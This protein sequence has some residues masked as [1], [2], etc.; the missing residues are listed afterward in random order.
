[1]AGLLR[2]FRNL[3]NPPKYMVPMG[4]I[5]IDVSHPLANGLIGCW[6]PGSSQGRNLA[7]MSADLVPSS[8]LDMTSDGPGLLSAGTSQDYKAVM[9]AVFTNWTVGFSLF[10]RGVRLGNAIGAANGNFCGIFDGDGTG[11]AFQV[12]GIAFGNVGTLQVVTQ[13]NS[14]GVF[15]QGNIKTCPTGMVTFMATFTIGGNAVLY[16]DGVSIDSVAFGASAPTNTGNNQFDIGGYPGI[17]ARSLNGCT[18]IAMAWNRPLTASDAI[19]MYLD[20]YGLLRPAEDVMPLMA[21]G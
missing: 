15:F 4:A 12:A 10:W 19:Q 8:S 17:A 3:L 16:Q 5:G 7:G 1:M 20:P 14:G 6:V 18:N 13:G 21:A 2:P 9:P 11:G